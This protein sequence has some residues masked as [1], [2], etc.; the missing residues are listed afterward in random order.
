MK[1]LHRSRVFKTRVLCKK[2]FTYSGV[3]KPYSDILK[4]YS[5]TFLQKK[6]ISSR[7]GSPIVA[8]L[9]SIVA[10]LSSIV[11]FLSPIAA[12]LCNFENRVFKTRFSHGFFPASHPSFYKSRLKNLIF[13]L[14]LEF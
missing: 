13:I 7:F 9:S 1:M 14:E 4:P 11:T 3:L 8:F 6:F 12:F 2:N 10:F 5:G